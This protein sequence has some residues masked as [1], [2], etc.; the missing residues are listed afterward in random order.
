MQNENNGDFFDIYH[1]EIKARDA[2]WC[3]W[4][5]SRSEIRRGKIFDNCKGWSSRKEDLHKLGF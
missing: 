5:D 2:A 1:A 4:F 3:T